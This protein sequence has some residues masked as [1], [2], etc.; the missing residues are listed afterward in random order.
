M[1]FNKRAEQLSLFRVLVRLELLF[2]MMEMVFGVYLQHTRYH[3]R[4]LS[5][6]IQE[7][8][9][10]VDQLGG[11][12]FYDEV[13]RFSVKQIVDEICSHISRTF[14]ISAL[15]YKEK[16]RDALF[17]IVK[18]FDFEML[19]QILIEKFGLSSDDVGGSYNFFYDMAMRMDKEIKK[20]RIKLLTE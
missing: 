5:V 20:T 1:D 12:Y 7:A 10:E 15:Q 14:K 13:D 6:D 16:T 9:E 8:I 11:S 4:R 17:T 2:G 18:E 19:D 3:D